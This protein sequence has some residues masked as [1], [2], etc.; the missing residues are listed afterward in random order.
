MKKLILAAAAVVI[1]AAGSAEAADMAVKYRPV[2][3]PACSQF[4]GFYIGINGGW[5]YHDKQW[6]D[7][8][9]W[10]DNFA[11]DFNTSTVNDSRN[12]GTVGGQ[13]GYNWQRN[14]TVFGIEID[15]NWA[16]LNSSKTYTP[17]GGPGPGT[18]LTLD[19]KLRWFGTARA[20]SGVIVD[21][22]MLYVTGGLAYAS[23]KHDFAINDALIGPPLGVESFS[24]KSG[25]WGWVGGVGAEWAWSDNVSIKSEV[26][27]VRFTETS[28]SGFSPA[29]LQTVNFD[30]NDSMWVSRIGINFRWGAPVVAKY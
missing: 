28:T 4:G 14:C 3:R 18:V 17:F 16:G 9:N 2:V 26:L 1:V 21:D 20:R 22:L 13:I 5:A 29:G 24:A 25:R 12:G 8:D 7:R 15:G 19:D 10:I 30:N 27:Y 23:I 6:V 11:F